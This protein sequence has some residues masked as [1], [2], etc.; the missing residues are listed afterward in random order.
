MYSGLTCKTPTGGYPL[1]KN[2]IN[3]LNWLN[4][5]IYTHNC[6]DVRVLAT[7]GISFGKGLSYTQTDWNLLN[8]A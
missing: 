1:N 8:I 2:I 7:K 3:F 6:H 4:L 5:N